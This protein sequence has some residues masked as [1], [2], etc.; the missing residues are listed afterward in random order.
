MTVRLLWLFTAAVYRNRSDLNTPYRKKRLLQ[1]SAEF[2]QSRN[3]SDAETAA[4]DL[5]FPY[6]LRMRA[7]GALGNTV[8]AEVLKRKNHLKIPENLSSEIFPER[9]Q[10]EELD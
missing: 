10:R 5:S 4:I 8:L 1:R 9:S 6:E 7:A 2:S 3:I